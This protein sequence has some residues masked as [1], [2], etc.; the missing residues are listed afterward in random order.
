[1]QTPSEQVNSV[2]LQE[3]RDKSSSWSWKKVY[4]DQ[5]PNNGD[6]AEN[7]TDVHRTQNMKDM[8]HK[9]IFRIIGLDQV[10]CLKLLRF[11]LECS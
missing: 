5:L 6:V 2:E 1:M 8:E 9:T 10:V 3:L 11:T 4:E 7:D